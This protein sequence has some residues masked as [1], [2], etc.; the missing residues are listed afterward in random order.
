MG[1]W[2]DE[3][4]RPI[5][6]VFAALG[7]EGNP[8]RRWPCP[9]C[10]AQRTGSDKRGPVLSTGDGFAWACNACSRK[11]GMLDALSWGLQGRPWGELAGEEKQGLRAWAASQGWCSPPSS[12]PEGSP[13]PRPVKP[14]TPPPIEYPPDVAGFWGRCRVLSSGKDSSAWLRGRGF[15]AH[16]DVLEGLDVA[17]LTP[18]DA[19]AYPGWWPAG[20]RAHWR[21]VVQAWSSAGELRSVHARAVGA[22]PTFDDGRPGVKVLWP[23]HPDDSKSYSAAG[24]FFANPRALELLRG[25][26]CVA[27]VLMLA[28]GL[29]DF[30]AAAG[31]ADAPAREGRAP[32]AVLGGVAGSWAALAEVAERLPPGLVIV[33]CLDDDRVGREYL[34]Q[35]EKALGRDVLRVSFGERDG[36]RVDLDDALRDGLD[37]AETLAAAFQVERDVKAEALRWWA[38][39]PDATSP[40]VADRFKVKPATLRKWRERVIGG[41]V[42]ADPS[43]TAQ[44]VTEDLASQPPCDSRSERHSPPVTAPDAVTP[45]PVTGDPGVTAPPVTASSASQ[46][47]AGQTTTA[48]TFGGGQDR[49]WL[50]G[51]ARLV[52]IVEAMELAASETGAK[53]E[54]HKLAGELGDEELVRDLAR[55]RRQG[56][57]DLDGVLYRLRGIRGQVGTVKD[58]VSRIAQAARELADDE[59]RLDAGEGV[60]LLSEALVGVEP[61]DA[62]GGLVVPYPY[63]ISLMGVWGRREVPDGR[64]MRFR[65][66]A[67]PLVVLSLAEEDGG[68]VWVTLG[69]WTGTAWARATIPQTTALNHNRITD[70][71]GLGVSTVG[72]K[73]VVRYVEAFIDIN[74]MRLPVGRASVRMG[75][76]EGGGFLWGRTLLADGARTKVAALTPPEGMDAVIAG[77]TSRGTFDGWRRA[78][79]LVAQYPR[80]ALAVLAALV[81]PMLKMVPSAPN[82]VVDWAGM[83]STGKTTAL[84]VAASIWGDPSDQGA[85]VQSWA[86]SKVYVERLAGMT[87]DLPVLLDDT[88]KAG[89][90][91]V[92]AKLVYDITTGRGAGR[93]TVTGVQATGTWRTVLLST[94]EAPCTSYGHDGGAEARSIVLWGSPLPDGS[95]ELVEALELGLGAN[96]GHLGPAW[97]EHLQRHGAGEAVA[98][99]YAEGMADW[100]RLIGSADPKLGRLGKYVTLLRTCAV[101]AAD[102]LGLPWCDEVW[103]LVRESAERQAGRADQARQALEAAWEWALARRGGFYSGGSTRRA[104]HDGWLGAWDDGETW[105]QIGLLRG[106]VEAHLAELGFDVAG[107]VEEWGRRGWL[108]RDGKHL[109]GRMRLGQGKYENPVRGLIL[110]RRIIEDVCG[111]G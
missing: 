41:A 16:L 12:A 98:K 42:T 92:I 19:A 101:L 55:I 45:S 110:P 39:N 108:H 31:W 27:R 1:D 29:T 87:S 99:V 51:L 103:H 50:R 15:G 23:K 66:F 20:R 54:L 21:L 68:A 72:A 10:G 67:R 60:Q 40:Q 74:R 43:V 106:P 59:A 76:Q 32:V 7:I 48:Y 17:R 26:A 97:V 36:K 44:G 70:V 71:E 89:D 93:G 83:T 49:Q 62:P 100:R 88:K 91:R 24:L 3:A 94:G 14:W 30:L 28:E 2:W 81:P 84:R 13:A 63:E 107:I 34:A 65:V 18:K 104:P 22:P 105:E 35:A 96:F 69:W 86:S 25:E 77:F 102:W 95:G 33:S 47:D 6:E 78:H 90:T 38:A 80:I 46:S 8:R 82:F 57:R 56:G 53:G 75:W 109:T 9:A 73:A 11:G 61:L 64:T 52:A 37:L 58:L 85:L 5:A 111:L 4:R 79:G